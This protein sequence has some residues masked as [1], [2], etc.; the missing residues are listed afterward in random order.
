MSLVLPTWEEVADKKHRTGNLDPLESFIYDN[1]PSDNSDEW[2]ADL[3]RA[4]EYV[5]LA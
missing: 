4:I 1:E 5:S 3:K 2:R